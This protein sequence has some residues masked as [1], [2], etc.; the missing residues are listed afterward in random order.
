MK[1]FTIRRVVHYNEISI[2]DV[3]EHMHRTD[4]SMSEAERVL[5]N[6]T[7]TLQQFVGGEWVDVP[8]VTICRSY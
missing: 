3:R 7:E 8:T 2:A 1:E 6:K 5:T 4:C